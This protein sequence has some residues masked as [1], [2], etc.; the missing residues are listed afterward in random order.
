MYSKRNLGL[1]QEGLAKP[2]EAIYANK[3]EV[4]I[5]AQWCWF[6]YS[7]SLPDNGP[8]EIHKGTH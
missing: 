7:V 5:S 2:Q 8:I 4:Y 6:S 1:V 3:K